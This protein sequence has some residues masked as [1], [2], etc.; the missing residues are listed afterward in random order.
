MFAM[1]EDYSKIFVIDKAVP[2]RGALRL[3]VWLDMFMPITASARER[4]WKGLAGA[5]LRILNISPLG[6]ISLTE[7][8]L[9]GWL[10]ERGHHVM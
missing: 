6:E 5:R 8:E 9:A 3:D 7:V 10:K 1:N 2:D 4:S